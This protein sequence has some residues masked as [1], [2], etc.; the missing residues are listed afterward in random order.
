MT[1]LQTR[2]TKESVK[3]ARVLI[4]SMIRLDWLSSY[5]CLTNVRLA[6]HRIG[7][8][9]RKP[10]PLE[11]ATAVLTS[12]HQLLRNHFS[13]FYPQIIQFSEESALQLNNEAA[14]AQQNQP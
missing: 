11:E 1:G 8:R 7:Q 3:R 2:Q 6:L 14:V 13:E 9:L 12:H 4:Q 10:V 5:E